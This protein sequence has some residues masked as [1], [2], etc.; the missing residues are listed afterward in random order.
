[1]R[2]AALSVMWALA[3]CVVGQSSYG[4]PTVRFEHDPGDCPAAPD[5]ATVVVAPL[6]SDIPVA[7]TPVKHVL[8]HYP[9]CAVGRNVSGIVDFAFTVEA[10]GS[11]GDPKIIQ[12]VPGGFG[13]GA[14]AMAVFPQW[15]FTPRLV[16]G[17]PVAFPGTYRFTFKVVDRRP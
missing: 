4:E 5:P 15:K 1:M 2:F 10:D 8:T 3:V 7:G 14:A 12:E 16:D 11:V 17:K 6:P 13:F 9:V